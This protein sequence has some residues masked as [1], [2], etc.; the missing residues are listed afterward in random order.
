MEEV[1]A[2]RALLRSVEA[3]A[4]IMQGDLENAEVDVLVANGRRDGAKKA[5]EDALERVAV[6]Q[7]D[8]V[9]LEAQV[10]NRE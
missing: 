1:Q 4:R 9:A 6:V 2:H 8:L 10:S 5:L 7:R 3:Y